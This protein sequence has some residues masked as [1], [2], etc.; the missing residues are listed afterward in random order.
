[1]G[2]IMQIYKL[3]STGFLSNVIIY[4]LILGLRKNKKNALK[5]MLISTGAVFII[6]LFIGRWTGMGIGVL[7][8]GM[9]IAYLVILVFIKMNKIINYRD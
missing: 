9:L 5:A 6:A 4:F 3:M 7:S 2:E 1:M 8:F